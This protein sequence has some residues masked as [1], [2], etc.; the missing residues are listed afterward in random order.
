M[1]SLALVVSI[2]I[3]NIL[4]SGP[5]ALFLTLPR[6]RSISDS[7]LF[8][9]VRRVAMGAAALTGISLSTLFLFNHLPLIVNVLALICI[10]THLWAA[11]REYGKFISSRLRRNG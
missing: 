2:M 1:E 7:R 4:F 3:G 6:I 8:L 9:I 5:F 10:A 11:D